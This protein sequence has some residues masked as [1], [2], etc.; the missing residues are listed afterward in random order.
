MCVC[1][2]VCVFVKKGRLEVWET[3]KCV[4]VRVSVKGI[5][6]IMFNSTVTDL[7]ATETT[8]AT[9]PTTSPYSTLDYTHTNLFTH[10]M[11]QEPN[12][13]HNVSLH[14][15]HSA[16]HE[17][18][19]THSLPS[20]NSN[21]RSEASPNSRELQPFTNTIHAYNTQT[22]TTAP[23]PTHGKYNYSRTTQDV[24]PDSHTHTHSQTTE[25]TLGEHTH[26]SRSNIPP[27]FLKHTQP[28]VK[29]P[30]TANTQPHTPVLPS[31][32]PLLDPSPAPRLSLPDAITPLT[33][34]PRPAYPHPSQTA[35]PPP[36]GISRP[37]ATDGTPRHMASELGV[38]LGC[39]AGLGVLL[40]LGLRCLHRRCCRKRSEVC[41]SER[42]RRWEG[43]C[44][45]VQVQEYG[46]GGGGGGGEL[47][48]VRRIRQ[49]SLLLLQTE[50]NLIT[51]PG[52]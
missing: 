7:P 19:K 23:T 21:M 45:V 41:L 27:P 10:P 46:C 49:N 13:T 2:C 22:H 40:T 34:P 36:P 33:P 15:T 51:P 18:T 32:S 43:E 11:S 50:Y 14:I 4:S 42:S 5:M 28:N 17:L 31:I 35:P 29:H 47:V 16:A 20:I 44:G 25:Y 9:L 26:T 6:F 24:P 30:P 37:P 38:L 8:A 12:T 3:G 48:Q 1:V 39:S 52:N